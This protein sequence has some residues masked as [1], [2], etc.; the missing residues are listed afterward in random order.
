MIAVLFMIFMAVEISYNTHVELKIGAAQ[1]DRLKAY[2]LA[3]SGVQI[4]LL[5]INAYKMV[6]NRYGSQLGSNKADLDLVWSFPFAWPPMLPTEAS[7][8]DQSVNR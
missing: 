3:K 8:F 2:Y 7:K 4:S 1:L 5:R 6:L